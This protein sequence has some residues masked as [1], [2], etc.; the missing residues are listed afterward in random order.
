MKESIC[1][2]RI[3]NYYEGTRFFWK[4]PFPDKIKNLKV[5]ITNEYIINEYKLYKNVESIF[6]KINDEY[7]QLN[8]NNR[9]KYLSKEYF[10][11]IIEMKEEDE[12]SNYLELDDNIIDS[13][14]N[15]KNE[16]EIYNDFG[17]Y[18]LQYPEAGLLVA[19]GMIKKVKEDKKYEFEHDFDTYK[20]SSSSPL[21]N[22]N[23]KVIGFHWGSKIIDNKRQIGKGYFI[24]YPIKE[25]IE[26]F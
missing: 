6:L 25:L 15:D 5:L 26:L 4:I 10:T 14:I 24:N 13:L 20:G 22:L 2:I 12:I 9:I 23:N 1:K 18:M 17:K 8:L 16:M 7:K 21:F 19:F 11:T 3:N